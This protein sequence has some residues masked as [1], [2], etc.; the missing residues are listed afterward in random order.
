MKRRHCEKPSDEAIQRYHWIVLRHWIAS[1]A[2][3][4]LAMTVRADAAYNIA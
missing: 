1:S 4:F 3:G 2:F